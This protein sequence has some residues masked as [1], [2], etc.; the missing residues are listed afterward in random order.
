[1]SPENVASI[2]SRMH[3]WIE[4]SLRCCFVDGAKISMSMC[5]SSH[6]N[7]ADVSGEFDSAYEETIARM[8]ADWRV[9]KLAL[10]RPFKKCRHVVLKSGGSWSYVVAMNDRPLIQWF[11]MVFPGDE[12][13]SVVVAMSS[14]RRVGWPACG[15]GG[16]F[17]SRV[18]RWRGVGWNVSVC[19]RRLREDGKNV[20]GEDGQFEQQ[21]WKM[22]EV[23]HDDRSVR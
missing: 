14:W 19:M 10:L 16:A 22:P 23:V 15:W 20:F 18:V 2:L 13:C 8:I 7:G 6:Q 17:V 5:R 12:S 1:M 3:S 21:Q 11:V 4:S 9:R